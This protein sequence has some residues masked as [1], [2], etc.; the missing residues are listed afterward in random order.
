MKKPTTRKV[1]EPKDIVSLAIQVDVADAI[2][3]MNDFTAACK[4]A[5]AAHDE[6]RRKMNKDAVVINAGPVMAG[7][8]RGIV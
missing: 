2:K 3:A 8:V 6:L 1:S 4:A 7:N 5:S